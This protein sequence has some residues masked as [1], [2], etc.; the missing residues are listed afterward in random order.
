M[1]LRFLFFTVC[2]LLFLHGAGAEEF[3]IGEAKYLVR[4]DGKAEL[5]EYKKASGDIVVPA[6]VSHPNPL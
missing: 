5:K 6:E 3:K 4:A 1:K 2:A